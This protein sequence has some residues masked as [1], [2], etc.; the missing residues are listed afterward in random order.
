MN[1]MKFQNMKI[2][3]RLALSFGVAFVISLILGVIGIS[4]INRINDRNT[5]MYERMT[6]PMGHL[7]HMATKFQQ[8]RV[9]LRDI[10]LAET[11][12]ERKQVLEKIQGFRAELAQYGDL[13]EKTIIYEAGRKSY[14]EY[15]DTLKDYDGILEEITR[16]ASSGDKVQIRALIVGKGAQVVK[17]SQDAME[18]LLAKKIDL[19]KENS[20]DNDKTASAAGKLVIGL[21]VAGLIISVVSGYAT[22]RSVTKPL[23]VVVDQLEHIS[24][25]DLTKDVP[26]DLCDRKDE[27]GD[28]ARAMH[29]MNESMRVLLRQVSG[30]IQTLASSSTELSAVS[31]QAVNSVKATSEKASTV[32]A[33][34]EEMSANSVSVAAG[35]EQA[36]TNLGTVASATEEMTSTI[37][38]IATNSERARSIT[39]QATQQAQQATDSMQ[40]LSQAAQEIGKVTETITNISDQTKLL[41]LNATIEAARAGAAGKGFA[42]VAHEIK[43][44]ARQTAEATE[45]IKAKVGGIQSKT[46]GTLEDLDKI[47]KVIAQVSEIVNTIA[48]AIEEQSSVTKDI[49]RNVSEAAAGVKDANER[50][51]QISTVSQSVAKDI[52][53]VNQASSE[54]ATGSQHVLASSSELSRLSEELQRLV[55][56]FKLNEESVNQ[57]TLA[58]SAGRA[59]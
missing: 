57:R 21:L 38:E 47:T 40:H 3:T 23:N 58:K 10:I 17:A 44:L 18:G 53:T 24:K 50:V 36:T 7:A 42:V 43:E 15:K 19:A 8:M 31:S 6:V 33:A 9:G 46:G 52:A 34:S 30:G 32:A 39:A 11:D 55:S 35:M 14:V 20:E 26:K 22:T 28:L 25:G 16:A 45:D 2:G 56:Q 48:T 27:C 5:V 54:I 13:Y 1:I 4:Q 37:G 51:A 41:A 29:A 59:G 49:A 12:V